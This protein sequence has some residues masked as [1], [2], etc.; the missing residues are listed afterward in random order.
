MLTAPYSR[1]VAVCRSGAMSRGRAAA[2][3]IA[4]DAILLSEYSCSILRFSITLL[5]GHPRTSELRSP[6]TNLL[7]LKKRPAQDLLDF[8]PKKWR[9]SFLAETVRFGADLVLIN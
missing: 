7:N 3:A 9:F 2:P 8:F 5:K 6:L 4:T 1:D